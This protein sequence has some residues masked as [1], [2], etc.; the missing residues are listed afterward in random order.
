MWHDTEGL[1]SA[2]F[3]VNSGAGVKNI[4]NIVIVTAKNCKKNT[5]EKK[6]TKLQL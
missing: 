1:T 2:F 3:S 5:F 4:S 6:T